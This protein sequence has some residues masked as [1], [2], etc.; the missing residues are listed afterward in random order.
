M[1]RSWLASAKLPAKFWFYA[2]K[3]AAEVC[4]YFPYKL[5]DGTWS[6]PLELAHKSKPDLRVLFKMFCLAAIQREKNWN[7]QI[8]NFEAQSTHMI[9]VGRCPHSN[10]L[11]IYNS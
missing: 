9:A 8:G 5:K 4:N 11:Q 1:A 7:S 10:G 6:T 3:R 2:V